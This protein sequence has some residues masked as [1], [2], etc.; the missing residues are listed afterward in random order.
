MHLLCEIVRATSYTKELLIFN[1]S[2]ELTADFINCV[3]IFWGLFRQRLYYI[4]RHEPI[5]V[6]LGKFCSLFILLYL[7]YLLHDLFKSTVK[8]IFACS[9]LKLVEYLLHFVE[10]AF[11]EIS[12]SFETIAVPI[13]R[14][15]LHGP[16]TVL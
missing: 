7:V 4:L 9:L 1:Q 11:T 10:H 16:V 13:I 15:N 3:N 6:P 12:I 14:S 8:I 2:H 5:L